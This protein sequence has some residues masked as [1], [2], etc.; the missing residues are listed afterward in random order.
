MTCKKQDYQK[1]CGSFHRS[2]L[3]CNEI[4][5]S[6]FLPSFSYFPEEIYISKVPELSKIAVDNK[7]VKFLATG[8]CMY[9]CLRPKD[10]LHIEP[11]TVK[12]IEVD[13]IA[14]FMRSSHIYSHRTIDKKKDKD[15][16]YIL[17][18]PDRSVRGNDGPIFNEDALGVISKIE[19][20]GRI[21]DP[22]RKDYSLIERIYFD[23]WLR[24][25]YFKKKLWGKFVYAICY[26][27]QFKPYKKIACFIFPK[28]YKKLSLAIQVPLNFKISSRFSQG[29]DLEEFKT[30]CLNMVEEEKLSRWS[31][32]AYLESKPAGFVSFIYRPSNCPFPG[33]WIST[34]HIRI[35]NRNFGIEERLFQEINDVFKKLKIKEI[36]VSFSQNIRINKPMFKNLNFKEAPIFLDG[37]AHL[38]QHNAAKWTVMRRE[39]I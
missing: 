20:K 7:L 11:K 22:A 13:D 8:T 29:L 35:R 26:L 1:T 6:S 9:P 30:N 37:L 25:Y 19:R 38:C 34:A 32:T 12:K 2:L 5:K 18:R 27:Q 17:T 16:H 4:D 24:R 36:F 23:S 33:W 3:C 31:I 15:M 39:V 21:L 10:T 14:V 28:F